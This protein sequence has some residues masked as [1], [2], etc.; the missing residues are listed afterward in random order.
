MLMFKMIN[1]IGK[2]CLLNIHGAM[3]VEMTSV[4]YFVPIAIVYERFRG[5]HPQ[6][7]VTFSLGENKMK[8][9]I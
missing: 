8:T 3:C 9:E 7:P 1:K 4:S 2:K 6:N 5:T